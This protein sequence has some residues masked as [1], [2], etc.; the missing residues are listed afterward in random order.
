MNMAL[1]KENMEKIEIQERILKGEEQA[2]LGNILDG[3]KVMKETRKRMF[4][5]LK[6]PKTKS[7]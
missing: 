6:S 4:R 3:N 2:D 5:S 1:N 7:L